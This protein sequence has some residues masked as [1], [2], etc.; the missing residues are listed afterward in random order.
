MCDEDMALE[1]LSFNTMSKDTMTT[2]SAAEARSISKNEPPTNSVLRLEDSGDALPVL[3]P[4]S[5]S[6]LD[7]ARN[8][9]SFHASELFVLMVLLDNDHNA[10]AS[11]AESSTHAAETM[12]RMLD[13][14]PYSL[15]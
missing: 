13:T 1:E 12:D 6:D 7:G 8:H 14:V 3:K 11:P 15:Q 9:I 4:D 10:T 5:V 2:M